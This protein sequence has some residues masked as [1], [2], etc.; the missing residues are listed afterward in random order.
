MPPQEVFVLVLGE[1]LGDIALELGIA[2]FAKLDRH[3]ITVHAQQGR[4]ADRQVY[5]GAALLGAEL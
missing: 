4:Y 2:Q 3:Q 1:N 5:V